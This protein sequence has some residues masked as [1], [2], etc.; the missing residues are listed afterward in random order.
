MSPA[1]N[2]LLGLAASFIAFFVGMRSGPI[3]VDALFDAMRI[4]WDDARKPMQSPYLIAA[5]FTILTVVSVGISTTLQCCIILGTNWWREARRRKKRKYE[6]QEF[7]DLRNLTG[8]QFVACALLLS[9][10]SCGFFAPFFAGKTTAVLLTIALMP[11]VLVLA[12]L[13]AGSR[14]HHTNKPGG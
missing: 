10:F 2:L 9:T 4:P 1:L 12:E 11:S 13:Y 6:G 3:F 14:G 5:M 7:E 8:T